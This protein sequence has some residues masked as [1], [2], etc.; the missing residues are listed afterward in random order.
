MFGYDQAVEDPRDGL[1]LF[2]PLDDGKPYGIRVGAVGSSAAIERLSRW[3]HAIQKPVLSAKAVKWEEDGEWEHV[4]AW[5]RAR[6]PFPGFQAT[7]GIPWHEKPALTLEV[8]DDEVKQTLRIDDSAQRVFQTVEVYS[9]R[10]KDALRTE[11]S[12]VDVWY[13]VIPEDVHTYC[14]PRSRVGAADAISVTLPA[15]RDYLKRLGDEPSLFSEYNAAAL[16]YQYEPDFHNQLKARLL[17]EKICIQIVRERTIAPADVLSGRRLDSQENQAPEIAWNL[18]T[19]TFYKTG[20]RPW[21]IAD[22]R[23][24]VC[25]I[26]LVFKQDHMSTNPRSA[27]C[28]A[29]MF[30]DSG[31]GLVFK[32][33]VGPWYTPDTKEFHLDRPSA[34]DLVQLAIDSYKQMHGGRPPR[35]LFLH[36]RVRFSDEEWAG[37]SEAAGSSMRP[38]GVRIRDSHDIKI[39]RERKHP[40]LRGLAYIRDERTAYLWTRG[41]VP[42]LRTYPG[43]EVPNP[44]L[45][46]VCRGRVPID[47]VLRDILALTKVNYNSCRFADGVPVT[48]RFADDVG[49]ILTAGPLDGVPPLQFRHYI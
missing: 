15:S 16:P 1:T 10:I 47:V 28:A 4:E 46:D 11:E 22:I 48:L 25:Y 32:G 37:F 45:I 36:G 17:R 49:E 21:K 39:F 13:V 18:A 6:P 3:V 44:L 38:I 5:E 29:Q 40:V 42:R 31:D 7:F 20:G 34:R 12:T 26:G 19:T 27:C 33:D 23:E 41:Y 2:G 9:R 35:E 14:R 30:L 8:P 43:R 24:G